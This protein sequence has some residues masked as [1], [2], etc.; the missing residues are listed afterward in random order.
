MHLIRTAIVFFVL[1]TS[2]VAQTPDP[3]F[4]QRAIAAVQ[5]Q[6]NLALDAAAVAEAKVATITEELNKAQARIKELEAKIEEKK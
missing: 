5:T 3:V 1:I 4:L 6:R 2:A